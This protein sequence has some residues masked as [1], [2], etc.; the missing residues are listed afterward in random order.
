MFFQ[1][2]SFSGGRTTLPERV[3]IL[4][5]ADEGLCSTL[6]LSDC[7][8]AAKELPDETS[9]VMVVEIGLSISGSVKGRP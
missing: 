5:C 8:V 1:R 4:S 6:E 7:V 2:S 3:V 9:D